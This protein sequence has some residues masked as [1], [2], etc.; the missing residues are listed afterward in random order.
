MLSFP[1]EPALAYFASFFNG[2]Y[3]L[4][5]AEE[6]REKQFLIGGGDP[7]DFDDHFIANEI[8]Q[9]LFNNKSEIQVG[10]KVIK[11]T[12]NHNQLVILNNDM[13]SVNLLRNNPDAYLSQIIQ[14]TFLLNDKVWEDVALYKRLTGERDDEFFNPRWDLTGC[15][16]E[17]K[18]VSF[19]NDKY[20]FIALAYDQDIVNYKWTI[21]NSSGLIVYRANGP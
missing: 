12:Y 10:D 11:K 21:I 7:V 17:I 20:R 9:Y 4:G 2:F 13:N 14:N 15:T 8:W 18:T 3:P 16:V 1:W 5:Q 6:T 19:G